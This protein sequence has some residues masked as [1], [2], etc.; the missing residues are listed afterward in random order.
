M[1]LYALPR[2]TVGVPTALAWGAMFVG[3]VV[4]AAV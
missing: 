2:R 3:F 1:A 4:F